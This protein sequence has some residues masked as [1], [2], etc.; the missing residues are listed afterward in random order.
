[1]KSKIIS[2][3]LESWPQ[4]G[5]PQG[6]V[7]SPLLSNIYLNEVL[8]QW[9]LQNYSSQETQMVRYADDAVFMFSSKEQAVNSA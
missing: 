5:T 1:M 6:S 4:V 7:I 8:D 3:G 9:F 2:L